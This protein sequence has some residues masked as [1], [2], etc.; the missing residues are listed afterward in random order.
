[1]SFMDVYDPAEGDDY[2]DYYPLVGGILGGISGRLIGRKLAGE[3][4]P[5]IRGKGR[6][7]ARKY[8]RKDVVITTAGNVGT[9]V[10]A[11]TGYLI[12]KAA[13]D[14]ESVRDTLESVIAAREN[15]REAMG[16][17]VS[18][19]ERQRMAA[20]G[21]MAA[22]AGIGTAGWVKGAR[23]FIKDMKADYRAFERTGESAN[24]PI[25]RRAV[26]AAAPYVVTGTAANAAG[27]ALDPPRRRK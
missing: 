23:R 13:D 9:G 2:S 17:A 27:L 19:P 3:R 20:L 16:N 7:K 6:K 26:R 24:R 14:P 8:T 1:M 25:L 4:D 12:G 10:G 18:T 22:G 11:G 21:L 15:A 5:K